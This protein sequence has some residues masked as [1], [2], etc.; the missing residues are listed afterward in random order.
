[1]KLAINLVLSL[2]MLA[3]CLYFVWPN[4]QTLDQLKHAWHALS[5]SEFAPYLAGYIG[6]LVVVHVCRAVRWN[7]LLAPIG[8]KLPIGPLLAISSVGFMAILALPARLGEFVRPGLLRQRGISGTQALG[9]I[10]VERIVDGLIISLLVFGACFSLRS[11]TSPPWMMKM[12]WIALGVFTAAMVFL[13]LALRRPQRTVAFFL[14]LSLLPKIAPKIATAIEDKLVSMIRGFEV[15]NDGRNLAVF[16]VWSVIYWFANGLGVWLLARGFHT[17][18]PAF[19]LSLVAALATMGIVAVGIMLP[20]SPGNFGQFQWFTLLGASITIIGAADKN[21]AI[22]ATAFAFANVHYFLQLLWYMGM[23]LLGLA[24][25]WV[26]FHDLALA[27]KS[28]PA[29]AT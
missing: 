6:L 29:E 20:N 23:G 18:D 16:V 9:T 21:T 2:G 24:T 15:L 25:P 10:A 7:N 27:R 28:G 12:A 8:V 22:Y 5:W 4:A 26:S 11:P 19:D 1:M 13:L 17:I 14:R 3:L